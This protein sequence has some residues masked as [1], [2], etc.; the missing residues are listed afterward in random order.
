M[1][2][3]TIVSTSVRGSDATGVSAFVG[4]EGAG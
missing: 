3:S 4:R 1:R 2:G